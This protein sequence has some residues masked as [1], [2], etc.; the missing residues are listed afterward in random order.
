MCIRDR[1]SR[2]HSGERPHQC[3]FEGCGKS[4][5]DSSS[6]ARHRRTHTGRRPYVCTVPSCGK[7]FT[8]RTTLNRHVR[9]HQLPMKKGGADLYKDDDN[10][11]S[12][13]DEPSDESSEE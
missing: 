10:A 8:R 5:S 12:D 7:M 6:L 3:E 11:D 9:S 13:E 2:V 4:F 1:H